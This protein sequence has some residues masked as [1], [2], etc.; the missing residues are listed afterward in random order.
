MASV[1][2][3]S[4]PATPAATSRRYPSVEPAAVPPGTRLVT[5]LVDSWMRSSVNMPSFDSRHEGASDSRPSGSP[6][7]PSPS[8]AASLSRRLGARATW[9]GGSVTRMNAA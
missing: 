6:P 1:N 5:D 3:A 7:M 8:A 4:G 2:A 9:P